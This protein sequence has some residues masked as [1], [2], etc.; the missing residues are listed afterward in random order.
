MIDLDRT[1]TFLTRDYRIRAANERNLPSALCNRCGFL[2]TRPPPLFRLPSIYI[3]WAHP[4]FRNCKSSNLRAESIM[5]SFA[6]RIFHSLD[7]TGMAMA[8]SSVTSA[9]STQPPPGLRIFFRFF[10]APRMTSIEERVR[11]CSANLSFARNTGE[12]A[13]IP[14]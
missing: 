7:G 12:I 5:I 9:F 14:A 2:P 3:R 6:V 8:S 1:R 13:S 11:D 4:C 10:L